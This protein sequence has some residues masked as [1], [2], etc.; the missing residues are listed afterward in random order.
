MFLLNTSKRFSIRMSVRKHVFQ[1]PL[2]WETWCT[3]CQ[4]SSIGGQRDSVLTVYVFWK[5]MIQ[6]L[7]MESAAMFEVLIAFFGAF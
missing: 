2:S 6:I 3:L 4:D 7:N 5:H 1:F